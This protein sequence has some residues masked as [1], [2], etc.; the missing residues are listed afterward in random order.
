MGAGKSDVS[1]RGSF[2]VMSS[3]GVFLLSLM[4]LAGLHAYTRNARHA[5]IN[6]RIFLLAICIGALV[7]HLTSS[8]PFSALATM[9]VLAPKAN[10]DLRR[11]L[12]ERR[13]R[14][15]NPAANRRQ[16]VGGDQVSFVRLWAQTFVDVHLLMAMNVLNVM[17]RLNSW[18]FGI[19]LRGAHLMVGS[20]ES[21]NVAR[22]DV[23]KAA[24]VPRKGTSELMCGECSEE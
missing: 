1:E 10:I 18:L 23:R 16:P 8:L 24:N 6:L 20:R 13:R 15:G 5:H 2:L 22:G 14:V 12:T 19:L 9:I 7:L 4:L 17:D 3:H 11:M 21:M